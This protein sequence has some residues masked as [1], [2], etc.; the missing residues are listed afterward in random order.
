MRRNGANTGKCVRRDSTVRL[1]NLKNSVGNLL[2]SLFARKIINPWDRARAEGTRC[3]KSDWCDEENT[4][5]AVCTRL[6]GRRADSDM[7]PRL[8]SSTIEGGIKVSPASLK[9]LSRQWLPV[10]KDRYALPSKISI[11]HVDCSCDLLFPQSGLIWRLRIITRG[12]KALLLVKEAFEH[13]WV[14]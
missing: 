1:L 2:I 5:G 6:K 11:A 8:L 4:A 12:R 3:E 14:S 10:K 13:F 9:G 7:T